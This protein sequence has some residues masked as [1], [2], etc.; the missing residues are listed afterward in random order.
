MPY[1]RRE[2]IQERHSGQNVSNFVLIAHGTLPSVYRRLV[3]ANRPNNVSV[4]FMTPSPKKAAIQNES[5]ARED[6]VLRRMLNTPPKPH[7]AK[8]PSGRKPKK[9]K[10]K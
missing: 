10:P 8:P 5:T 3:V 7:K 2:G 4:P 6:A 1:I 9:P